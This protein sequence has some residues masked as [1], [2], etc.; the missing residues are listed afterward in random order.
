M[1]AIFSRLFV[2]DIIDFE[3]ARY[4][5]IGHLQSHWTGNKENVRQNAFIAL[6]SY[7]PD[8]NLFNECRV[9]FNIGSA[10]LLSRQRKLKVKFSI[11]TD[12][13]DFRDLFLTQD[14]FLQFDNTLTHDEG[15]RLC[16]DGRRNTSV[17]M[18]L[19]IGCSTVMS[20]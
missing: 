12:P 18:D 10:Q 19:E 2:I 14:N 5:F 6:K 3:E 15:N 4:I 16:W 20:W 9:W 8:R 13:V 11:Q 7:V 17:A 1:D